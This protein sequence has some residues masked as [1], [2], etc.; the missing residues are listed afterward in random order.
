M[1]TIVIQVGRNV[2]SQVSM[3]D[4]SGRCLVTDDYR[5][6]AIQTHDEAIIP[7]A[8]AIVRVVDHIPGH[9]PFTHT[10]D[11]LNRPILTYSTFPK[12]EQANFVNAA[13]KDLKHFKALETYYYFDINAIDNRQDKLIYKPGLGARSIGQIVFKPQS[14][15]RGL[16]RSLVIRNNTL[17]E[18]KEALAKQRLQSAQDVIFVDGHAQFENEGF[19]QLKQYGVFQEYVSDIKSEYRIITSHEGMPC[20]SIKRARQEVMQDGLSTGHFIPEGRPDPVSYDAFS[21]DFPAFNKELKKFL[22]NNFLPFY[23]IDIFVTE[24]GQWG[25]F[26]FSHEFCNI[27][28]SEAGLQDQVAQFMLKRLV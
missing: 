8:D 1:K 27:E 22:F 15:S 20:I 17:A 5:F 16:L 24:Q 18:F 7:G 28:Y 13:C 3:F 21:R 9:I 19:S 14:I 11:V 26:E 4:Y 23:S 2:F 10:R 12:D 6:M 25:I